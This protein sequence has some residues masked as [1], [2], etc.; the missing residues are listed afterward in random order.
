MSIV[1]P[2]VPFADGRIAGR[3]IGSPIGSCVEIAAETPAAPH[4]GIGR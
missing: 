1:V 2:S 3:R 4:A